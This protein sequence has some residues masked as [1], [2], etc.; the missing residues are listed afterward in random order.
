MRSI[1]YNHPNTR[2]RIAARRKARR[3]PSRT[4][5]GS[6]VRPGPRRQF[7]QFLGTGRLFSL[8]L[9][10]V[11]MGL[12]VYLF[13]APRFA[14]AQVQ[15]SGN[16]LV[17]DEVLATAAGVQGVPIWFVDAATVAARLTDNVYIDSVRVE[18]RLPDQ[19]LVTVTE[20][21]PE[22]RW[23]IGALQY[24]VDSTGKVLGPA[25][26]DAAGS[27]NTNAAAAEDGTHTD[28]VTG[29][30]FLVIVDRSTGNLAPGDRVDPDA[31]QLARSLQARL[32]AE[33]NFTPAMIGWDF[34]L[35]VYVLAPGG[36]TI[37]FGQAADLDR[38]LLILDQLLQDGTEFT[39]LDLR[40]ANPFYQNQQQPA[41]T[42]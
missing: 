3:P 10:L 33:L 2:E 23:Q 11:T 16:T 12:L 30:P 15:V 38:K 7:G 26:A 6:Q 9:F 14:I 8:V 18:T 20:R 42:Q 17:R 35:G 37:I 25:P 27:A 36:Q 40:P 4:A 29:Q 5:S 41:P 39:Y 28:A 24:L 22:V 19:V 31:L 34:V 1:K 32:P 21:R 13:V